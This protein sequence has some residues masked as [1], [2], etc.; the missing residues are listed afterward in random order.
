MEKITE[1]IYIGGITTKRDVEVH[2][3]RHVINLVGR[4]VSYRSKMFPLMDSDF[5]NDPLQF[6]RILQDIDK[7]VKRRRVPVFIH[8][9]MGMSRSPVVCALYLYYDQRFGTFE[10]ALSYVLEMSRVAKPN[11]SLVDFVRSQVVP[12]AVKKRKALPRGQGPA[13][14]RNS[15]GKG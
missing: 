12:L 2:G 14:K 15:K 9:A 3:I 1:D 10:D 5:N 7:H 6:L 4:K 13:A 8:C 11:P